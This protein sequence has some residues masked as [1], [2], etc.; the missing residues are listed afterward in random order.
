M[1][2][3]AQSLSKLSGYKNKLGK[4]R[5][6]PTKQ[7][8]SVHWSE[9]YSDT[10]VRKRFRDIESLADSIKQHGQDH[11]IR[12]LPKDDNGYKIRKGERRWRACKL[13]DS[14]V[15]IVIDDRNADGDL[16][17][18][19]GQIVENF[20]RDDLS[21]LELA[22][23][24]GAL[25]DKGMTQKDIAKQVGIDAPRL[26]KYL[27]LLNAPECIT[28][29][30]EQD[31]TSDLELSTVLR[32]IYELDPKRCEQMCAAAL[33]DGITRSHAKAIL[34]GLQQEKSDIDR[35]DAN[36]KSSSPK[37]DDP[38]ALADQ[39]HEQELNEAGLNE[40]GLELPPEPDP[41]PTKTSAKAPAPQDPHKK[42]EAALLNADGF[43]ERKP[44]DA[45]ILCEV[46]HDGLKR[47]GVIQLH[48]VA[49][50]ENSFVVRVS[51]DAG[52]DDMIVVSADAIKLIGYKQ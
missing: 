45:L 38:G 43:Y 40:N 12:V 22:H 34:R 24:F 3:D 33:E 41:E 1:M 39:D 49:T 11:P 51:N 14:T 10:Q 2:D 8:L 42:H 9:V 29:L 31:V 48:L 46:K 4:P 52:E 25:S 35:Q 20:Q 23:G 37:L 7:I 15:D 13:N 5:V 47:T 17:E 26:S 44:E 32:K 6:D 30:Y 27:S 36:P 18:L 16:N 19:I 21:P 50:E 28:D